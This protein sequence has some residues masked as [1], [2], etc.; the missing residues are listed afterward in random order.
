VTALG[1]A[2]PLSPAQGAPAV[3]V[4]VTAGVLA[5]IP[6]PTAATPTGTQPVP[7]TR[8][9][10]VIL[11]S[12][13]YTLLVG[14]GG[15]ITQIAAFT[16]DKVFVLTTGNPVTVLPQQG[17]SAAVGGQD[18]TVYA[19]WYHDEP[20]GTYPAPT[21]A[22]GANLQPAAVAVSQVTSCPA[23]STLN[24]PGGA[25]VISAIGFSGMRVLFGAQGPLTLQIIWFSDPS[26]S[27]QTAVRTVVV[28]ST[29]GAF[30]DQVHY[31]DYFRVTVTSQA[32]APINFSL[33]ISQTAV[34]KSQWASSINTPPMLLNG[35]VALAAPLGSTGTINANEVYAGP[36]TIHALIT[37][38]VAT[39]NLF[40]FQVQAMDGAGAWGTVLVSAVNPSAG[41][42][43]MGTI[44]PPV[45]FLAPAAPIRVVAVNNANGAVTFLAAAVADDWR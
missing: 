39:P 4:V 37:S 17:S 7:W 34:V 27:F 13:P 5:T 32:G 3:P 41:Q 9:W 40:G 33:A 21:G 2:P 28:G 11:N 45:S 12:S 1:A 10:V 36:V 25:S 23:G 35:S 29:A 38:V 20:P 22:G 42:L 24:F 43:A 19:T 8:G 26:G 44:I 16:S 6:V 30:F 31:G 14:G 18:S 15:P